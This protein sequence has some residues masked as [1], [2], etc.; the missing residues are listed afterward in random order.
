MNYY[1]VCLPR[2]DMEHC[3][4][5]GTYGLKRRNVI[6]QVATGDKIACIVTREPDWKIIALGEATSDY[7]IDDKQIFREEGLFVDRFNFKSLKLKPELKLWDLMD[8][9]KFVKKQE[10]YAAYFKNGIVKLTKDEWT[11]IAEA[12]DIR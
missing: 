10:Y 5:I 12:A 11:A 3:I 9:L 8:S 2:A 7:Y 4:K 1:L 6:S